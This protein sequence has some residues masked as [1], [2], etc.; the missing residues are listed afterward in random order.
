MVGHLEVV[1]DCLF[2]DDDDDGEIAL[3]AKAGPM[4]PPWDYDDDYECGENGQNWL[5]WSCYSCGD[6]PTTTLLHPPLMIVA[7]AKCHP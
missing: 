7:S 6:R 4:M 1:F 5:S 2:D 3:P